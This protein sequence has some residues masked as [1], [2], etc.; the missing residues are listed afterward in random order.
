MRLFA[1]FLLLLLGNIC[2]GAAVLTEDAAIDGQYL[3]LEMRP[4][5][6]ATIHT[7]TLL[8][9]GNDF[10]GEGGLLQEGFGV[11]SHYLPNRRLNEKL[12]ALEEFT[13]RPVLRFTYD[14][15][16]PNIQGLH[17]VRIME[18]MPN[19]ASVKVVWRVEN[20]GKEGQWVA[21]WVR[22]ELTPGG[23]V[24]EQDRW[25]L[26]TF[27]GIIQPNS[28]KW[29]PASRNWYAATDPARQETLY[30]VFHAD[31]THSF[32]VLWDEE[33]PNRRAIQTAFVPFMLEPGGAWETTYRLNFVRGLQHVDFATDE[34]AAQIDYAPA[35][36]SALFSPA[37]ALPGL[38]IVAR[39]MAKNGRVWR[40]P[41][42]K[43]D[44]SPT[45]LARC[46]YEWSAPDP[47]R[48]DFLAQIQRDGK[49]LQ[50]GA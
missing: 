3:H 22:N 29:H 24:D 9:T 19:E 48:F 31:Q 11:A 20:R 43:F 45:Q 28:T 12:E 37:S 14:C 1:C 18:L 44:L 25:D 47:G 33:G 2:A 32:L 30:C 34:L 8:G 16:G 50:L 17:V 49:A 26:P 5:E 41:S 40:L 21:P 10:A 6:G 7:F 36:L 39:V 35:K 15:Q 46:S 42:K 38:E 23:A 4:N 13:E 27:Q